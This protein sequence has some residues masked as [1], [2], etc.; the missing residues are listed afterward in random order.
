MQLLF[1]ALFAINMIYLV[2]CRGFLDEIGLSDE[3]IGSGK[4]LHAILGH[5]FGSRESPTRTATAFVW[6]M[7][8]LLFLSTSGFVTLLLLAFHGDQ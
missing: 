6:V 8:V 2:I 4:G 5:V 3:K 1:F 7:R